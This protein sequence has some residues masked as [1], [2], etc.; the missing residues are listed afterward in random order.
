MLLCDAVAQLERFADIET[1]YEDFAWPEASALLPSPAP[2]PVRS[3]DAAGERD[4]ARGDEGGG[5]DAEANADSA[6]DD[7]SD[8]EPSDVDSTPGGNGKD[9]HA[10][11]AASYVRAL[12]SQ[13]L[14]RGD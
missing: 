13:S 4:G 5:D 11:P 2:S 9:G 3:D 1:C 12:G 6:S 7:D 14:H 10:T 8:D